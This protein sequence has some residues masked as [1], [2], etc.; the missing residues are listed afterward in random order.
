MRLL[1]EAAGAVWNDK[2]R[3]WLLNELELTD[4]EMA[5]VIMTSDSRIS[6]DMTL[7]YYRQPFRTNVPF[8]TIGSSSSKVTLKNCFNSCVNAEIINIGNCYAANIDS[9]FN[10][11]GKL[12]KV[13]GVIYINGV[14]FPTSV[15]GGSG[16]IEDVYF[17]G[18]TSN[19][20]FNAQSL[21]S[22]EDTTE[23]T[24]GY[25]IE[26]AANTVP[27]TVTLHPDAY[28]RVPDSLK[29]KAQE[30]QIGLVSV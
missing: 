9:M 8:S 30:K 29:I 28:S 17:D 20:Y 22:V 6:N 5:V 3:L 23:S 11:C 16:K 10:S 7:K 13:I 26:N 19:A 15:F 25:L 1:F 4:E 14:N 21:L 2:K 24:L 27:I 12:R 18:L